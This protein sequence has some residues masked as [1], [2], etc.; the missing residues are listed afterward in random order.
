MGAAKDYQNGM[1]SLGMLIS[2]VEG[3]LSVIED[4]ALSD[5]LSNALFALEEI[6]AYTTL[7]DYD[8]ETRGRAVVDRAVN[9]IVARTESYAPH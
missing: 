2:K 5:K 8:F 6:H 9:E 7:G 4:D 3:L 1:M